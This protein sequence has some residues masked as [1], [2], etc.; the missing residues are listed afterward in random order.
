MQ[1]LA[2]RRHP[3]EEIKLYRQE[4]IHLLSCFAADYHA[5][6]RWLYRAARSLGILVSCCTVAPAVRLLVLYCKCVDHQ[7][8]LLYR[9]RFIND[10]STLITCRVLTPPVSSPA[11][12][13]VS[14]PT[15]NVSRM[16][17]YMLHLPHGVFPG[18]L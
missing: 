1:V 13:R 8:P 5:M 4:F 17:V 2:V 12:R 18:P 9:Y 11:D 10:G 16:W 15:C 14:R 7:Y 6:D 3:G